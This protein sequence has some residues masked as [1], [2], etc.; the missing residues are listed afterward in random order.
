M[1]N[2]I[3]PCNPI[4]YDVIGAFTKL[5]RIDWKQSMKNINV[6][7]NVYIYVSKPIMA[8]LFKCKV[9]KINLS[10]I[11]IDDREFVIDGTNYEHYGNHMELELIEKYADNQITMNDLI[12]CGMKG[13]VQSPRRTNH[14]IQECIDKVDGIKIQ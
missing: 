8:I 1:E 11:E 7:D 13:R 9:R 12:E 14:A 10:E 6:G 4:F 3:I 5:K 2:W